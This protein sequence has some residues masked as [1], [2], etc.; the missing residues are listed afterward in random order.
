LPLKPKT[1]FA[2]NSFIAH[3]CWKCLFNS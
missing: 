1:H 2:Q 3:L